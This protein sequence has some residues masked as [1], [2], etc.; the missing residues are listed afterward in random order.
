MD[1]IN[2]FCNGF[3]GSFDRYAVWM[4]ISFMEQERQEIEPSIP[5]KTDEK[6]SLPFAPILSIETAS[7]SY[8]DDRRRLY[9]P[10]N[11]L[12]FAERPRQYDDINKGIERMDISR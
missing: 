10:W 4:R 11:L 8:Y 12:N 3:S 2:A 7:E 1:K 6:V 9:I 5:D